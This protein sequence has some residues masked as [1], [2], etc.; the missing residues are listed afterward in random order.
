MIWPRNLTISTDVV[1]EP[2]S[3]TEAKLYCKVDGSAD[4]TIFTMLIKQARE[5]LEELCGVTLAEKTYIAEWSKIP[6][7]GVLTIPRPPIKSISSVKVVYEDSTEADT[8]LTVNDDYY[9]TKMPWAEIRVGYLSVYSR[10]CLEITYIAGYGAT[11]CPALPYPLKIA[12]LKE[13]LLQYRYREGLVVDD[14]T[15]SLR[16]EVRELCLPYKRH[17]MI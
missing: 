17:L 12:L 10:A 4:D 5:T 14:L 1:T 8:T 2:V 9:L 13:I 15:R 6:R 3:S 16:N 7:N 11:G